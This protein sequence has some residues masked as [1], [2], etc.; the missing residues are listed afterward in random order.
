MLA[1]TVRDVHGTK[2]VPLIIGP[3]ATAGGTD[4]RLD[5]R[6]SRRIIGPES[7]PPAVA[8]GSTIRTQSLNRIRTLIIDPPATAGGT[9][10]GPSATRESGWIMPSLRIWDC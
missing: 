10:I 7:V 6:D 5:S 3:P 9:D 8:G 4:M 1:D 2:S